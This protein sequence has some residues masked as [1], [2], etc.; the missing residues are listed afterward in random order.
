MAKT[1]TPVG[2]NRFQFF[3]RQLQNIVTT[4]AESDNPAL[5]LY[6]QNARTSLFMLEALC[7]MYRNLHNEKKFTKLQIRF[8][9]LEDN[10]GAIDYYDGFLKEF[11]AKRNYST[12]I[13]NFIAARRDEQVALLNSVLKKDKWLGKESKRLSK[14]NEKLTAADWNSFE[15]DKAGILQ[16]YA[17]SIKKIEKKVEDEE[18]NFDDVETDVHELRRELRWLSIYP[19]ALQGL[20]QLTPATQSPDFLN[21]YLTPEIVNSPFNKMPDGSTLPNH[22]LLNTNYFLALSWIIAELGKLKDNGL[23]IVILAEA[24]MNSKK[25][26]RKQA[27]AEALSMCGEG[28]LTTEMILAKAKAISIQFFEERNLNNLLAEHTS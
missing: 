7:R 9:Q 20:M 2:L 8:K 12:D 22:I 14:I 27:E 15:A 28:Q 5:Y 4:A 11:T 26:N 25:I 18:I 23:R 1:I 16:Y 19:Q 3:L 10:I 21:K 24:L 13:L 17:T 6:E